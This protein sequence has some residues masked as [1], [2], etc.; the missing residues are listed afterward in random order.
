VFN[1]GYS[2]DSFVNGRA[3]IGLKFIR[4][5]R[6]TFCFLEWREFDLLSNSLHSRKQKV[7]RREGVLGEERDGAGGVVVEEREK[8]NGRCR[9]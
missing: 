7:D 9:K 4:P 3:N 6:Q 8:R 1:F 2:G 5:L